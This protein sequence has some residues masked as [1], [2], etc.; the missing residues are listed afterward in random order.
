MKIELKRHCYLGFILLVLLGISFRGQA[1]TNATVTGIVRDAAG[2][3]L[4]DVTVTVINESD[5]ASPKSTITNDK[6]VFSFSQLIPGA[7]Y[8]FTASHVGYQQQV[9]RNYSVKA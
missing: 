2:A 7:N 8:R 5:S 6:G 4:P 3:V 1:Q 9:I